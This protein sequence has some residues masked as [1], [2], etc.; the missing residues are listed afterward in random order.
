MQYYFY[1]IKRKGPR[2]WADVRKLTISSSSSTPV[3][4]GVA[5]SRNIANVFACNLR[6]I[7]NT[8][9]SPSSHISLQSSIQSAVDESDIYGV[10]FTE[11]DVLEA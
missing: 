6:S 9:H 3:V 4:D 8:H 10:D 2:F 1:Y 7:L 5:G 11:D